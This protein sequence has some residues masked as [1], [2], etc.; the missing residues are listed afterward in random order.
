MKKAV[1]CLFILILAT[2]GCSKASDTIDDAI[3]STSSAVPGYAEMANVLNDYTDIQEK[4]L[5]DLKNVD[6]PEDLIKALETYTEN[7]MKIVPMMQELSEKYP[8]LSEVD[9]PK[10]IQER[11]DKIAN[12]IQEEAPKAVMEYQSDPKV[13]EAFMKMAS[14]MGQSMEEAED[15]E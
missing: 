10:H 14:V 3:D 8:E 15:E 4:Y 6:S 2:A 11:L 9:P 13:Q 12:E 7:M 5:K 1:I